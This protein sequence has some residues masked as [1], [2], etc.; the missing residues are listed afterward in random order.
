MV[1]TWSDEDD[2]S[3]EEKGEEEELDELMESLCLMAHGSESPEVNPDSEFNQW[4]KFKMNILNCTNFLKES[5]KKTK[6]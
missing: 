3:A 2:E 6:I 1:V 5:E 4:K